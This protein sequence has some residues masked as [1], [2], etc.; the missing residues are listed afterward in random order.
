MILH[1]GSLCTLCSLVFSG[2]KQW[3]W[4]KR[5]GD[6]DSAGG[7]LHCMF[8]FL[9]ELSLNTQIK[10]YYI[11]PLCFYLHLLWSCNN[12]FVQRVA[13]WSDCLFCVLSAPRE[14]IVSPPSNPKRTD[15][16]QRFVFHESILR[17]CFTFILTNRIILFLK[18]MFTCKMY[19]FQNIHINKTTCFSQACKSRRHRQVE[20]D[21]TSHEAGP[22]HSSGYIRITKPSL[23]ARTN[24]NV[25]ITGKSLPQP[26]MK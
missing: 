22:S 14:L 4:R 12:T 3:R 20:L 7:E 13:L 21:V 19:F 24:L 8:L 9:S 26:C 10:V 16:L 15:R 6:V 11:N 2:G 17:F 18:S 1:L 25:Q 5:W 23:K